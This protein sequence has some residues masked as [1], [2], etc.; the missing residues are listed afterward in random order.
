MLSLRT[1]LLLFTS[2]LS[3]SVW[4]WEE[5]NEHNVSY[6][7][8]SR[9]FGRCDIRSPHC[10]WMMCLFTRWKLWEIDLRFVQIIHQKMHL[11]CKGLKSEEISFFL[12]Y[13]AVCTSPSRAHYDWLGRISPLT[14]HFL[15]GNGCSDL[16]IIHL[17]P[18]HYSHCQYRALRC[19]APPCTMDEPSL[20]SAQRR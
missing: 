9:S 15:R 1:L 8:Y 11:V 19:T 20:P 17:W 7:C 2:R 14:L 13:T 3:N 12:N 10:D 6:C 5:H 18:H 4:C 16:P